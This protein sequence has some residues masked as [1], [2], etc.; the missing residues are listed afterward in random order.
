MECVM[1]DKQVQLW[2]AKLRFLVNMV[3]PRILRMDQTSAPV[4]GLSGES[5]GVLQ[6]ESK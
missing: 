1:K 3:L 4:W 2:G 6:E 5:Y